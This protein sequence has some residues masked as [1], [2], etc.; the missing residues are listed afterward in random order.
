M[1]LFNNSGVPFARKIQDS[2]TIEVP[3]IYNEDGTLNETSTTTALQ[4]A[5]D[6]FIEQ[7]E[8]N[9]AHR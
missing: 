8:L 9:E 6:N 1:I 2:I 4:T 5:L 7:E 3:A